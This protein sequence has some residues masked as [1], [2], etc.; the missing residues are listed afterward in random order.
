MTRPRFIVPGSCLMVTRR[1]YMQEY[2][3]DPD[4]VVVGIFMDALSEAASRYDIDVLGAC[5]MSNH[6]HLVLHDP[7]GCYPKFVGRFNARLTRRINTYRGRRDSMWESRQTSVVE[8]GDAD[9]VVEAL[10]YIHLNPVAAGAVD[11]PASWPGVLTGPDDLLCSESKAAGRFAIAV[12][13]THRGLTPQQFASVL[14]ERIAARATTLAASRE[15]GGLPHPYP[16]PQATSL[17][18]FRRSVSP[19][20][21]T[22]DGARD[23]TRE[24]PP[25]ASL[26]VSS[27][28][29]PHGAPDSVLA[30]TLGPGAP[31]VEPRPHATRVKRR[32]PSSWNR[33]TPQPASRNRAAHHRPRRI[34]PSV[35]AATSEHRIALLTRIHDFRKAYAGALAALRQGLAVALPGGTWQLR[36]LL[37]NVAT[38][39]LPLPAWQLG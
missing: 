25:A 30:P 14:R 31:R 2:L 16:W 39:P 29:S 27:D 10:A 1:C 18:S 3:L 32:E 20:N 7:L 34:N 9:S 8:L 24:S 17:T 26:C 28:D 19:S 13:P 5:Q 6:Y 37:T 11:V 12:P 15:A 23:L 36:N 33:P 4:P 38:G 22:P 21:G 35:K